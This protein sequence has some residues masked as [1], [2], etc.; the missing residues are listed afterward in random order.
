MSKTRLQSVNE[1]LRRIGKLPVNGLDTGGT[2]THA[3][4]ER[5]LD[6]ADDEIQREGWHWNTVSDLEVNAN[7][8]GKLQVNA[9]TTDGS[10]A[11]Q[12]TYHA[13]TSGSSRDT[14]VSMV[15]DF[16]F[17]I[18]KNSFTTFSGG[19]KLVVSF[20]RPFTEVPA[21]FQSWIIS[22]AA[23]EYLMAY[24]N[25]AGDAKDKARQDMIIQLVGEHRRQAYADEFRASDIN[26]LDQENMRQIR[27]RRR[28]TNRS[29]Y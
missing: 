4:V 29:I 16:L 18:E 9:L 6:E 14:N 1:I 12:A 19:Y 21:S 2:S 8:D 17:D 23:M 28:M 24:G 11:T 20:R 3:H 25:P 10:G 5:F 22:Q 13:D 7:G 15:G 27:G 26:V